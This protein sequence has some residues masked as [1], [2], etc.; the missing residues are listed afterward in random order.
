MCG[1]T[2]PLRVAVL[3]IV[4]KHVPTKPQ[5]HQSSKQEQEKKQQSE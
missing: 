4:I 3:G 5:K 2:K 1:S